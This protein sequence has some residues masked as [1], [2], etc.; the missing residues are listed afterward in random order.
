MPSNEAAAPAQPK[1]LLLEGA[2]ESTAEEE[3][4]AQEATV[5]LGDVIEDLGLTH[6]HWHVIGFVAM[7]WALCGWVATSTVYMLE[8]A[9]EVGGAWETLTS[10]ADRLTVDDRALLLLASNA[11][12]ALSNI[13]LGNLSD[14]FGRIFSTEISIIFLCFSSLGFSIVR[15]KVL[16]MLLVF[17]CPFMKDGPSCITGCLLAEWLPM[18]WRGT[19]VVLL[20]S[21]WS[22]GRIAVTLLWVAVPPSQYWSAFFLGVF[23]FPVVACVLLRN[24]GAKYESPRWLAVSGDMKGCIN[25]LEHAATTPGTKDRLPR[26]WAD[27]KLLRIEKGAKM[28]EAGAP[29]D[30][31]SNR[32]NELMQPEMRSLL[33][34]LILIS[35]SL[36]FASAGMFYWLIDYL[37]VIGASSVIKPAMF[38]APM[39]KATVAIALVTGRPGYCIVDRCSRI[40]LFKIGFIGM[41]FTLLLL[42]LARSHYTLVAIIVLNS[43]FEEIL[44]C[45]SLVYMTEVFPTS[46]RISACGI[47]NA[48]GNMGGISSAGGA[49]L[50]MELSVHMPWVLTAALLFASSVVCFTLP[51][52]GSEKLSDSARPSVGKAPPPMPEIAAASADL[53][54]YGTLP[55]GKKF[56]AKA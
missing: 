9:S 25:V 51:D 54:G 4:E 22:F 43:G 55:G 42:C 30:S 29:G 1:R 19:F 31:S 33:V 48:C 49:G 45:I 2:D 41:G 38:A 34:K 11:I 35:F 14:A 10:P 21:V 24:Y 16:L 20:H 50:L 39:A 17:A 28:T 15:N 27:P 56:I 37:K 40:A 46:L 53:S 18:T 23:V 8:A 5:V 6:H 32:L 47:V 44:W 13:A 12:C 3:V 52:R 36:W 26:G 7:I